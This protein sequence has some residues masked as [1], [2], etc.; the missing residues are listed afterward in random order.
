[1][2]DEYFIFPFAFPYSDM[3]AKTVTQCLMQ[4]FSIFGMCSYIHSDRWS[5]FQSHELKSCLHSHGVT[6]SQTTSFNH[7]GNGQCEKYNGTTVY[8]KLYKACWSP[9]SSRRLIGRIPCQIHFTLFFP[10]S[11]HQQTALPM[12]EYFIMLDALL[13]Y[14]PFRRGWNQAQFMWTTTFGMRQSP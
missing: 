6:T 9:G 11:A 12:K 8:G 10:Y 13:L 4:L 14:L 3:T 2:V 1:M 5:S 7:R